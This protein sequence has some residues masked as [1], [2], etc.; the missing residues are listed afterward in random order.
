MQSLLNRCQS[1][2]LSKSTTTYWN[3]LSSINTGEWDVIDGT[4]G[5]LEQL[6]LA[7]DD[8]SGDYTRLTR[9]KREQ[10]LRILEVSPTIT[11]RKFTSYL[12]VY[13]TLPLIC[14]LKPVILLVGL[15]VKFMVHFFSKKSAWY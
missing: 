3:A 12:A 1:G 14:G 7:M 4:D 2:E 8:K 6:T 13:M 15:L 9:F 10:I 5:M 11:L